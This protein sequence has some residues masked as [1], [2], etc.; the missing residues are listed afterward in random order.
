MYIEQNREYFKRYFCLYK[1]KF[2]LYSTV[3]LY[4]DISWYIHI[5]TEIY[6][7]LLNE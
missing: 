3:L 2:V 4:S 6:K 5:E 7:K 1:Y